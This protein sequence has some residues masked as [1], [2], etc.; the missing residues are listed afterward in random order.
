VLRGEM[1][2][3]GP[4]P[5][6][7]WEASL[8]DA[9]Y[10]RRLVVPPGMTG[11]WQTSGRNRLTMAEALELDLRYVDTRSL[12]LDL[13]ILCRTVSTILRLEGVR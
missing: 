4:R 11:L 8:F 7:P 13:A 6:L 5:V 2:L 12:R 9:R 10:L 1:A 3:V